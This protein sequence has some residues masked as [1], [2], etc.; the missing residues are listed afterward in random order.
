MRSGL[1]VNN[2]EGYPRFAL[3][4]STGKVETDP[5][6]IESLKRGDLLYVPEGLPGGRA[7]DPL[8]RYEDEDEGSGKPKHK[9]KAKATKRS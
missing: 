5:S 3:R 1:I 2:A 9:K 8:L 7:A 4:R 6:T